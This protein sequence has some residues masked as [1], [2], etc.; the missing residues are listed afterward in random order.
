MKRQERS[1][2]QL[3]MLIIGLFLVGL[4]YGV[5]FHLGWGSFPTMTLIEGVSHLV[6]D[7]FRIAGWLV[8]LV[9]FIPIFICHKRLMGMTTIFFALFLGVFMEMGVKMTSFLMINEL[10]LGIRLLLFL[11][12]CGFS[13]AGLGIILSLDGGILPYESFSLIYSEKFQISFT[14]GDWVQDGISL[15]LG[16]LLG[17]QWGWGTL[18]VLFICSFFIEQWIHF[19]NTQ[20]HKRFQYKRV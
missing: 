7:N 13:G 1:F 20:I 2:Y 5:L 4:A 11:I 18:G 9:F 17:A 6:K 8:H 10:S 12:A 3:V 14:M 15:I 19:M 16:I